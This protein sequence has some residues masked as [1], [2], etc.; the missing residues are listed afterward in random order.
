MQFIKFAR[1]LL[2]KNQASLHGGEVA[3][4]SVLGTRSAEYLNCKQYCKNIVPGTEAPP[5]ISL[6]KFGEENKRIQL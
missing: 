1:G 3:G 4:A 2:A 6:C 5:T